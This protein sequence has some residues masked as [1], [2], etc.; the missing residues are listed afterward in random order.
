MLNNVAAAIPMKTRE[1]NARKKRRNM[2]SKKLSN[3]NRRPEMIYSKSR[4]RK[5][6]KN[7][8]KLLTAH[9]EKSAL[10]EP[11]VNSKSKEDLTQWLRQ[12]TM[13]HMKN[14]SMLPTTLNVRN[15]SV[16]LLELRRWRTRDTD[17]NTESRSMCINAVVLPIP[18]WRRN[19][20]GRPK[21]VLHAEKSG[22]LFVK[23]IAQ[24]LRRS[25]LNMEPIVSAS[26]VSMS[27]WREREKNVL[28]NMLL[29]APNTVLVNLVNCARREKDAPTEGDGSV[30]ERRS[31][32]VFDM[33]N[34]HSEDSKSALVV[35]STRSKNICVTLNANIDAAS[36]GTDVDDV[37]NTDVVVNKEDVTSTGDM[38]KK[39]D[40]DVLGKKE[41]VTSVVVIVAE[42]ADT[43]KSV[44][45][46]RTDMNVK[47]VL[48]SWSVDTVSADIPENASIIPMNQHVTTVLEASRTN[49]KTEFVDSRTNVVVIRMNVNVEDVSKRW[50]RDTL[51]E[52]ANTERSA[53]TTRTDTLVMHALENARTNVF[54]ERNV[55]IENASS[56]PIIVN[57]E[58]VLESWNK[59]VEIVFVVI[60]INANNTRIDTNVRNVFVHFDWPDVNADTKENARV[61]L[62]VLK[63]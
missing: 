3:E 48:E 18:N 19:A 33:S 40:M 58:T 41:D 38:V 14:A 54:V 7:V 20:K 5:L 29:N 55:T 12:H 28:P 51:K 6:R 15:A 32:R 31:E 63:N 56:T 8:R 10:R 50:R 60:V 4:L 36:V 27:T 11:S 59:N 16:K 21:N 45:V 49:A 26:N 34:M 13:M 37:V 46:T 24:E 25:V 57:A 61:I 52:H 22:R 42:C 47:S 17:S 62:H 53:D 39:E 9:T 44:V 1:K 35:V 23:W 30:W 2:L 43:N